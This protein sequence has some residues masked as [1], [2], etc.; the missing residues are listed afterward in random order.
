MKRGKRT[1]LLIYVKIP[2]KMDHQK[3]DG[4]KQKLI[5]CIVLPFKCDKKINYSRSR[6]YEDTLMFFIFKNGHFK[7]SVKY[8][9][10]EKLEEMQC[11]WESMVGYSLMH[12]DGADVESTNGG[13]ALD[14]YLEGSN[15]PEGFGTGSLGQLC[16]IDDIL[17][18][19]E[20][21]EV[22]SNE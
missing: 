5:D 14:E 1:I 10:I 19:D 3:A 15:I 17:P 22:K 8:R 9:L 18:E 2:P 13:L 11:C 12:C 6:T 21:E 7:N 4:I 20:D 16:V